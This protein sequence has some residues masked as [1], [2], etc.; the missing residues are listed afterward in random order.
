[1]WLP[2]EGW[3]KRGAGYGAP[4]TR[5]DPRSITYRRVTWALAIIYIKEA[6]QGWGS[7]KWEL[8]L[9]LK[10]PSQRKTAG[11]RRRQGRPRIWLGI[12]VCH[13]PMAWPS[14]NLL[15]EGFSNCSAPSVGI[16]LKSRDADSTIWKTII[17][18]MQFHYNPHYFSQIYEC[19]LG[20][21]KK[22][23]GIHGPEVLTI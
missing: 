2:G 14:G 17:N 21:K 16:Q 18:Q 6:A 5:L 9:P 12:W 22:S 7:K 11:R 10:Q 1:M 19:Q 3:W 4:R 15:T 20:K 23:R 13:K 8:S